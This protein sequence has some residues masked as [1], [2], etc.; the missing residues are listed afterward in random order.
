MGILNATFVGI[1]LFILESGF[2]AGMFAIIGL[3]VSDSVG[4]ALAPVLAIFAAVGA[5][6]IRRHMRSRRG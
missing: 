3:E 4:I 5:S 6:V 2:L 1:V